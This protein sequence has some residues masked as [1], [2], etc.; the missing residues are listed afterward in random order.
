MRPPKVNLLFKLEAE[1]SRRLST[2]TLRSCLLINANI[3]T[4]GQH[5]CKSQ[6]TMSIRSGVLGSYQTDLPKQT[7]TRWLDRS[8]CKPAAGGRS[9]G[10]FQVP[11]SKGFLS[12]S[13]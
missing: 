8:T 9:N 13:P 3:D 1:I 7:L 12:P 11:C 5:R 4:V 2:E 6:P 10:R